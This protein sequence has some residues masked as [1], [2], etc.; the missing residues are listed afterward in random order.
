MKFERLEIKLALFIPRCVFSIVGLVSS[1][2]R[3][4]AH[5]Y[6]RTTRTILFTK[7]RSIRGKFFLNGENENRWAAEALS[8]AD[9]NDKLLDLISSCYSIA[10]SARLQMANV[11]LL[12][13]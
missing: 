9:E 3:Q 11:V 7:I 8:R 10:R 5:A 4:S 13:I 12:L 2:L 6:A 1:A